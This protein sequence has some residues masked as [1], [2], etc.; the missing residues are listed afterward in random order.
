MSST[1]KVLVVVALIVAVGAVMAVKRGRDTEPATPTGA[2]VTA[3]EAPQAS[4][5]PRLVDLGSTTCIPCKMMAPVLEE[6]QKE[7]A[8]RLDVSFIDVR[9]IPDAASHFKIRVIPTQIFYDP[10]GQEQYRHEGFLSKQDI[11]AK[12]KELGVTLE[13]QAPGAQPPRSDE[14]R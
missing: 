4:N 11:L 14:T 7:Y 1:V 8:G 6:L 3:L 5:L 13:V 9:K 10:N 12:W 2:A